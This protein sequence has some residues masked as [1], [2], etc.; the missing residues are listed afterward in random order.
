[1]RLNLQSCNLHISD[2]KDN[3]CNSNRYEHTYGVQLK[4]SSMEDAWVALTQTV[5]SPLKEG[6]TP[7]RSG[8]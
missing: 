8:K 4:W 6:D 7:L 2:T 5:V 3:T 1:M